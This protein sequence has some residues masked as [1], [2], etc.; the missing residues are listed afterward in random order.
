MSPI[1]QDPE[2]VTIQGGGRRSRGRRRAAE[3]GV[4]AWPARYT[5]GSGQF[6][7]SE[8]TPDVGALSPEVQRILVMGQSKG[9][10]IESRAFEG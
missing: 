3:H 6:V 2:V 9:S 1:I 5:G 7:L 8:L 4:Y 10:G